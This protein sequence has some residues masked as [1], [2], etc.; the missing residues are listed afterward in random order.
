[1]AG[2]GSH[3]TCPCTPETHTLDVLLRDGSHEARTLTIQVTGS[4]VTPTPDTQ[5]PPAPRP[6]DPTGGVVLSCRAETTLSWGSVS[7]PSG[8]TG[9]Y[10]RL[11]ETSGTPR[12]I[13]EWGPLGQ[14]QLTVPV[15][16]GY[17]YRWSVR[18]EDGAGNLG[19]WSS[20]ATFG[21]DID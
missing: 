15:S 2:V 1:V 11:E 5:G 12:P 6:L 17:Y 14:T 16:C 21:V 20:W 9:Y 8:I 13:G 10:V 3:Q 4:C 7:A 19:P 18:A